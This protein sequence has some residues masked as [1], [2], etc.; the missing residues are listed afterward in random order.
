[1]PQA[2]PYAD[3]AALR[4]VHQRRA[5]RR[6]GLGHHARCAP[7][8]SL[9]SLVQ[10][11]AQTAPHLPPSARVLHAL[12]RRVER[13]PSWP[14]RP[15]SDHSPADSRAHPR[16]ASFQS[17][18]QMAQSLAQPWDGALPMVVTLPMVG[19]LPMVGCHSRCGRRR[20]TFPSY[21]CA[22]RRASP[23]RARRFRHTAQIPQHRAQVPVAHHRR[24]PDTRQKHPRRAKP[25]CPDEPSRHL[26]DRS[27]PSGIAQHP[28]RDAPPPA[29]SVAT[30]ASRAPRQGRR[31]PDLASV[32]P[33]HVHGTGVRGHHR[34]RPGTPP[35]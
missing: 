33:V 30:D 12:R 11:R 28:G 23:H 32:Q 6:R 3:A 21:R 9:E 15:R 13:W 24:L 4:P 31:A 8:P 25:H 22:Q 19:A 2:E 10:R 27:A 5:P 14:V 1:M 17:G 20:R 16:C 18:R 7:G 34:A 26:H 29:E 35:R